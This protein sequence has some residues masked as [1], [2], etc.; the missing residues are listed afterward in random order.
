MHR[1]KI[2]QTSRSAKLARSVQILDANIKRKNAEKARA[3][4]IKSAFFTQP[5]GGEISV[6]KNENFFEIFKK[7]HEKNLNRQAK[8]PF[9]GGS[10]S[11][12]TPY[13]ALLYNNTNGG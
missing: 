3:C 7:F 5:R 9:W 12:F 11:I 6:F 2:A 1:N 4:L 13:S 10:V 8:P